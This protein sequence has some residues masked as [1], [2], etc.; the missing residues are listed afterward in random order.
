MYGITETTVH[1]TYRPLRAAELDTARPSPIGRPL[2]DLRVH[3]LDERLQPVPAGV[4]GEMHVSGPGLARGYLG[5]PALTAERFVPDPYATRPGARMYRTG[6]VARR[7]TD[8]DLEFVGRADDQV[9]IRGHRIEPA[10]VEAAVLRHPHVDK[11]VV[12]AHRGPGERERPPGGLLRARGRPDRRRGGSARPPRP[13]A[14]LVHGAGPVRRRARAPADPA[15]QGG[16]QG[17]A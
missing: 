16:P 7:G 5:R 11:S 15:R 13:G 8:G 6:D 10:E 9:K 2:D 17:A 1:V 14:A 12:V 3:L 4:P